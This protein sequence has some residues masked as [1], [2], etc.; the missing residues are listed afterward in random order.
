[1]PRF[2]G[3]PV[4]Q[5][6]ATGGRFGGIAVD[7][8]APD[9]SNVQSSVDAPD[10]RIS[11]GSGLMSRAARALGG[12][13]LE[14]GL[15]G[16]GK[17]MDS[18]L[19]GGRQLLTESLGRQ[20]GMATTGL[21][22]AGF[23]T[24]ANALARNVGIPLQLSVQQQRETEAANRA[25]DESGGLNQ[26]V[27]ATVGN[28]TGTLAQLIGP[29][30]A[31]R[32]TQ[33]GSL[34]LPKTIA[35]NMLVGA[36]AGALQPVAEDG[37]RVQNVLISSAAGGAGALIPKAVGAV[38]RPVM[39][40]A[41]RASGRG[42][43]AAERAAGEAIVRESG[44]RPLNIT[45]S[46][47][48][49]VNRTLGEATMD[50]GVMALEN[51]LR[52]GNRA[53]FDQIDT[54]NNIARVRALREIAGTD[55]GM[56]AAKEA[57]DTATSTLRGQAFQEGG[58]YTSK[59]QA[60]REQA[61]RELTEQAQVAAA[62]NARLRQ[63]GLPGQVPVQAAEEIAAAA[64]Q[65]SSAGT[66][67]LRSQLVAAADAEGGR[68]AVQKSIQEVVRALDSAEDSVEGLYR[69]RKTVNDLIE[70]KAGTDK[71]FARAATAELIGARELVDSEITRRAPTFANY[72]TAYR[73]AS[74]PINRMQVGRK[75]LKTGSSGPRDETGFQRLT[76]GRFAAAVENLDTVAQRATGFKK[77]K[78]TDILIPE[79]LRSLEAIQDD[80]Q[81]QFKRQGS[82]TTGSQTA[83]RGEIGK[84]VA[85]RS[86]A[87]IVPFLKDAMDYFDQQASAQLK[88]KMAYLIANPAEARRVLDALAPPQKALVSKV[89][90]QLSMGAGRS[91]TPALSE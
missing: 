88:E 58:E 15:I 13:P 71:S 6:Q 86:L 43:T 39:E 49:G 53:A 11:A 77:A 90:T 3:V 59:A 37:E 22:A 32:G 42:L 19:R 5:P 78:A 63:L 47:V 9:F 74:A 29:G 18:T 45:Q 34:F 73:S 27:P 36:G 50:P 30:A 8:A 64:S 60:A 75:V 51:T 85:V 87:R 38:V 83:E 2:Q 44:G 84:R 70:G 25:A 81:R 40:V 1:M 89:L 67:Q 23:D 12:A 4:N 79:D 31:L 46:A 56:A 28:I 82:A 57:R 76:P 66:Q 10:P 55:S 91:A 72:L 80:M 48:P 14:E 54:A 33:A 62:E 16:L 65:A 69:V 41:R 20:T 7:A 61:A 26:S 52:A 35:G 17:S 68:T 24:A 21:K